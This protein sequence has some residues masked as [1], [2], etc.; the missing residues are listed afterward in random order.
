MT[1]YKGLLKEKEAVDASFSALSTTKPVD[2]FTASAG[3]IT[4]TSQKNAGESNFALPSPIN[5]PNELNQQ[6]ATLMNSLATL[7]AEKSRME[8]SFQADKRNLRQEMLAKDGH[9]KDL[10][11]KIKAAASQ[12]SLELEKVKSKLIVERHARDKEINDHMIMVKELQKLL[13]DE[14]QL[15]ENFEMQLNNLKSQFSQLDN[16]D[17]RVKELISELDQTKRK[18][19]DAN[20]KVTQSS[21]SSS[22]SAN[23]SGSESSAGILKQLQSEMS[24]MRQQHAVAIQNEQRRAMLAEERSK[25]LAAAH[26]DRVA[27]LESR[28]AELSAT[29]GSYDRLRQNDQDSI[30]KLKDKIAQ[31][32]SNSDAEVVAAY[33]AEPV[34]V[35][36]INGLVEEI[37]LL[38]K[39][40]LIE[41]AKQTT[42]QDL[43]KIF[44]SGNDHSDCVEEYEKLNLEYQQYR[45]DSEAHN[46]TVDVQKTHIRTL[47]DKIQVLNR[48]IDEQEQELKTKSTEHF[49][50][51]K[52]ERS[53]WRELIASMEMDF[54]GK[55]S[56]LEHQL[57][58]QRERSLTLLEEKENEIK[59]LK[60]SFELFIPGGGGS[61][62]ISSGGD[63]LSDEEHHGQ[64]RKI[65]KLGASHLG[66][67][68]GPSASGTTNGSGSNTS[69][70][71]ML[72]YVHELSRKEV[73]ITALRKAKHAAESS[74]RQALQ[75]KVTSQQELHDRIGN[76]EDNVDR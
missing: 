18:L 56:E 23:N 49:A 68:L 66:V 58:K 34:V 43:S 32:Q 40:L 61:A 33:N 60:T 50:E 1:A 9:I 11:M 69:D 30:F 51:L 25:K 76:L 52:T 7:S 28:L 53:K 12:S 31:L 37:G 24:V 55:L 59:T 67:V 26:E 5:E 45:M 35:K 36:D 62:L 65:S 19:K 75:D 3:T 13:S 14:R 8:A 10:Q 74:L 72:H 15:K 46:N 29:V 70:C 64:Q 6:L 41:N 54:R 48:N 57:Q 16:T 71:H 73:E 22:S 38:K 21:S 44:S 27:S 17:G 4:T 63:V 47:Q 20:K 39:Q 2:D 42:P